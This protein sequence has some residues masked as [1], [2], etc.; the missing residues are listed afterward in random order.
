M[1]AN[2]DNLTLTGYSASDFK[3]KN[4]APNTVLLIYKVTVTGRYKEKGFQN[5][6]YA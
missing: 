5:H 4:V 6:N 3:D 2:L 1:L